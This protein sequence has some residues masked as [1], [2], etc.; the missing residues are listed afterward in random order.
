[1]VDHEGDGG[2]LEHE[3]GGG[4]GGLRLGVVRLGRAGGKVRL[5]R[6][7]KKGNEKK[8]QSYRTKVD[9]DRRDLEI[10]SAWRRRDRQS[11]L[12]R[13]DRLCS[14]HC[15]QN[16][17]RTKLAN[18]FSKKKLFSCSGKVY[19]AHFAPAITFQAKCSIEGKT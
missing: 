18:F 1:M 17:V 14:K 19:R 16:A 13:L 11:S 9:S 8:K 15:L 7:R 5:R 3:Q 6:R 12:F 10:R 4:G 2:D